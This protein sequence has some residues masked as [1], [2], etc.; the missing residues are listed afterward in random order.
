MSS[1][2]TH[3]KENIPDSETLG[4]MYSTLCRKSWVSPQWV[5]SNPDRLT[6]PHCIKKLEK[7]A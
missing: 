4:V 3:F 7:S 6:C 2:R 5:T 1:E